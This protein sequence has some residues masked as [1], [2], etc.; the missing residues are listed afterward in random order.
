MESLNFF[1]FW[2]VFCC[3]GPYVYCS[4]ERRSS[5]CWCCHPIQVQECFVWC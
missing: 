3:L 1:Y 2:S 5:C 4:E